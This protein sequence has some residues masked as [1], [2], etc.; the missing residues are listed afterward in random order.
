M[1]TINNK[2]KKQNTLNILSNPKFILGSI[3]N[4]IIPFNNSYNTD[5]N[6]EDVNNKNQEVKPIDIFF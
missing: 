6:T 1:N 3:I 4:P 5:N 2:K